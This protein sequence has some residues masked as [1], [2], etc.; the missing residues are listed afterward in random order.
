[1]HLKLTQSN[2]SQAFVMRVPIYLQLQN[3]LT[4]RIFNVVLHGDASL[5]Q[6]VKLPGKLPSPPKAILVNYNADVLSDS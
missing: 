2:V 3:G 6:T 1:V 5:D 4:K